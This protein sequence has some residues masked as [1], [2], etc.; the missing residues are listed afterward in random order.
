METQYKLLYSINDNESTFWNK[1]S[2]ED[3]IDD[4]DRVGAKYI[5]IK[6]IKQGGV[7]SIKNEVLE[8]EGILLDNEYLFDNDIHPLELYDS[9]SQDT[10]DLYTIFFD[11]AMIK[12][13][14]NS[15]LSDNIFYLDTIYVNE[16][17][18]NKGF[19]TAILSKLDS[20]LKYII[21]LNVGTIAIYSTPFKKEDKSIEYFDDKEL[22]DK[23]NNLFKKCDYKRIS[24]SNYFYKVIEYK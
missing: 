4:I 6:L 2:M 18:R 21:G 24:D 1:E 13:E 15:F 22:S 14:Y 7:E 20:I 17:Y 8:I 23:L 12:E 3:N 19:A 16:K 5:K 9:I 10:Y 11:N